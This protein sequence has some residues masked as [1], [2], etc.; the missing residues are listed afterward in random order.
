MFVKR[1]F[2]ELKCVSQE[3]LGLCCSNKQAQLKERLFLQDVKLMAGQGHCFH[4][5][6]E[7]PTWSMVLPANHGPPS[8]CR[9]RRERLEL[10]ETA[11]LLH[12][13][14]RLI[15]SAH[16]TSAQN[17][18]RALHTQVQRGWEV[19]F[20]CSWRYIALPCYIRVI[21]SSGRTCNFFL[22]LLCYLSY[23]AFLFYL[24]F[25]KLLILWGYS[26]L[27]NVVIGFRFFFLANAL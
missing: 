27:T 15:S 3:R 16:T 11:C 1:G 2:A 4:L 26:Q 7:G 14:K 24:S 23:Y 9:R 5:L 13:G 22:L 18:H 8:P 17:G 6:T 19:H 20:L 12:W 10:A 21:R 25:F